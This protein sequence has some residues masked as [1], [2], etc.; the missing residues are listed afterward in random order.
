MC[1][2]VTLKRVLISTDFVWIVPGESSDIIL[3]CILWRIDDMSYLMEY[4]GNLL[5]ACELIPF[6][7]PG[8]DD[9]N[10]L[11]GTVIRQA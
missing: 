10:V 7:G 8:I 11:D 3:H 2:I 4:C 5:L 6:Q 1:T 9:D